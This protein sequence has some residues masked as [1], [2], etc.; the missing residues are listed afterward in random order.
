MAAVPYL[1]VSGKWGTFEIDT[2]VS[3][4]DRLTTKRDSILILRTQHTNFEHCTASRFDS[5]DDA[6][7][8][9]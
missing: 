7:G 6:C 5:S 4:F 1:K 3:H 8:Q 9:G 2:F